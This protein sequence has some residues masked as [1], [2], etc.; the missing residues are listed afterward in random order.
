MG[1]VYKAEDTDLGRFVAL[2]FLPDDVAKDPHALERFRREARAASALNHPNICT[3][4]EIGKSEDQSFIAM[5]FLEGT[6]LKHRIEDKPV[7]VEIVL[8]LGIEIA[9][10]LNAAHAKG[11]IHRDIKPA[12]IFVTEQG[13]AKILDFGLTKVAPTS[14]SSSQ[15]ESANTRTIE[16]QHLTSPGSTLGTV[17]YMSPEQVRAK[18][19]DT[20]TDLFSFGAVLYEM[21][22][23]ALPFRGESSGVIFEAILNRIPVPPVRLNPD[24]PAELERII[25]KSLEKDRNLRYQHASGMRADL[26]RLKRDTASGKTG[27]ATKTPS[28]VRWSRRQVMT[29]A[30]GLALIIGGL[31]VAARLYLGGPAKR[32]ESIAVL[33]LEN[34]SRDPEQEYFAD[35]M[36]DA[37]IANLSKISAFRVI[38]RTSTMHYKGTN[39]SLPEIARELNVEGVV[40]GSVMRSGNRVRITAQLIHAHTDKNLW[41]ETYERDF[42]DVLRLQGEVAQAIAQQVRTRLPPQQQARL[43]SAPPVNPQALEAYLK[44]RSYLAAEFSTPQKIKK[45]QVYFEEA[46]R[47]DAGLALAYVGLADCYRYL[48]D[49]RRL[50]PQDTYRLVKEAVRKALELDDTLGEAHTTLGYLSWRHEWDWQTAEREFKYALELDPNYVEGRGWLALYLG[51]SGRR[52]EALAEVAKNRILDPGSPFADESMVY[53]H[54]RDYTALV[55]HGQRYVA[56]HPNDWTANYHLAVGYEGSGQRLEAIT[57]Y[58]NAVDLSEGDADP[59][60]ALAHAY[61]SVGIRAEAEKILQELERQSKSSYVSP[62]M[63]AAICAGLG[64]KEKAFEF[65]EKAYLERSPDIPY[66]LKA[67]LRIDTLRS[68]PRFRDLLRRVGLPQ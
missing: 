60:A 43:R 3:I 33:P 50:P 1:V 6:T 48:G 62:Y 27:A 25:A 57:E 42:G 47:E 30:V 45:A 8:S 18:E 9:D 52:A 37:L 38:S 41:A 68:D 10:G 54:L 35:G 24:L 28:A 51:W 5:E 46:I 49:F 44:G 20:R 16:A 34:L 63:M 15:L 4:Y 22:T 23:G 13:H 31:T 66:F 21:A 11:V 55:E 29:I 2:K 40:E 59:T 19:L 39:K 17:A 64:D 61:A 36:T 14:P 12:N 58:Q 32:I 53:Y 56:A 7:D 67:D 65:L 26:Q